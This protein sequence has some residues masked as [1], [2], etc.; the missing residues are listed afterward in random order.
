MA[1]TARYLFR[2][3]QADRSEA[4][5]VAVTYARVA[6]IGGGPGGLAVAG[7]LAQRGIAALVLEADADVGSTWRSHYDRLHLHT[8]RWLSGLPGFP[9]PRRMGR[10]VARDDVVAYLEEYRR[11][12]GI[13]VRSGSLV[14]RVE[15]EGG[16]GWRL[17]TSTGD[18]VARR[19][20][21]AA[22]YNRRPS[23]PD[24]PGQD[25]FSGE[26]V[27]SSAYR[28]ASPYRDR[29][30]LVAG[31]GNSGAEIAVDLVEGGARNV[32]IAVRTPPNIQKREIVPG[33]PT[34]L[35]GAAIRHLPVPVVDRLTL[36]VQRAFIGDLSEFGL[37]S[38][39][40]G[41]YSRVLE[42][43]RIPIID[44]GLLD[45]VRARRVVVVPAVDG[46]EG[47]FV[48][49]S[50]GRRLRVDA[51]VAATGFSRALEELV[52]HLGVLRAN[53]RPAA[54][55]ADAHPAA[56]GLHFVGY[57]NPLS[58]NLLEMARDARRIARRFAQT[59]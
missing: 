54:H 10:W 43:E 56:P 23:L 58:G 20:V 9:I 22:G 19:V 37:E 52:G 16:S 24:W 5:P 57:S 38:P 47:G 21:V 8:V 3:A 53:G 25:G 29:D 42:E 6:V 49:L 50:D 13:E 48:R 59:P 26:I 46:F 27:H 12:M 18:V 35:V 31:S 33:V 28:N 15:R 17:H 14:L 11:R 44:V 51:V 40:R 39:S 41:V 30:V 34:Q 2:M 4:Q 45:L 7:A 55:G 36:A 1:S 32:W